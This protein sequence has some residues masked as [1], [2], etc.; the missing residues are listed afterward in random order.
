MSLIFHLFP[1]APLSSTTLS[2]KQIFLFQETSSNLLT[3]H[4]PSDHTSGESTAQMFLGGERNL[5]GEDLITLLTQYQPLSLLIFY[6]ALIWPQDQLQLWC[7]MEQHRTQTMRVILHEQ[8]QHSTTISLAPAQVT[9][10]LAGIQIL[11]VF[12]QDLQGN[13]KISRAVL[14]CIITHRTGHGDATLLQSMNNSLQETP[15]LKQPLAKLLR[16]A[17]T[18]LF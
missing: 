9:I 16:E 17:L 15:I 4:L 14:T 1:T 10:I 7:A 8:T 3:R 12:P 5:S 2:T 13:K 11:L 6:Q 18:R